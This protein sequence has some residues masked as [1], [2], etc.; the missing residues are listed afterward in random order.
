MTAI[1]QKPA[2]PNMLP[3]DLLGCNEAA[4]PALGGL[5]WMPEP[6]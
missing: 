3:S 4:R 6:S 5:G 2:T 1:I